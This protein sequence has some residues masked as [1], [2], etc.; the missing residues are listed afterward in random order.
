M[1]FKKIAGCIA[2]HSGLWP[3]AYYIYRLVTGK[4]ILAAFTFHRITDGEEV[5]HFYMDYDRGLDKK[6]FEIQIKAIDKYFDIINLDR[7]IDIISGKTELNHHSALLTFDDADSGFMEHAFAIL[8]KYNYP[9]TIFVP[10]GLVETD[11][12]LWHLRI[13]NIMLN[14]TTELWVRVQN[15]S[16]QLPESIRSLIL[17]S[18]PSNER[19]KSRICRKL[20]NL[21]DQMDYKVVD[22]TLQHWE[23][24]LDCK[25]DLGIEC[26]DWRSLRFLA[27]NNMN[28]E[29]HSMTHRKLA[30]LDLE[31]ISGEMTK[32]KSIIEN[33][34][35]QP[36]RAICYPAGSF[37]N[38]VIDMARQSCYEVG[39]TTCQGICA[40][41]LKGNDLFKIHRLNIYGDSKY[42]IHLFLGK[43]PLKGIVSGKW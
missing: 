23:M 19:E 34:V 9:A 3:L 4:N 6:I 8:S 14:M 7:Y 20:V 30:Q 39:L 18:M 15:G 1:T 21:M 41:P 43:L 36:V 27:Q 22:E 12:R 16:D 33:K 38:N 17:S 13:S 31:E 32:S 10:V 35:H 28:I 25:Y 29:S 42:M 2:Y 11:K 40:Y 5:R 37:N 26:M 24:I